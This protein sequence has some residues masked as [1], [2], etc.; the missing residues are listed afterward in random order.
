[1]AKNTLAIIFL[2]LFFGGFLWFVGG[3]H[4]DSMK[5]TIATTSTIQNEPTS[6]VVASHT[7][8]YLLPNA[9][10]TVMNRLMCW[11]CVTDAHKLQQKFT[12]FN[13]QEVCGGRG[14]VTLLFTRKQS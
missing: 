11:S 1:M 8:H 9:L 12:I 2:I 6:V 3:A 14:K 4:S 7:C 13:P 10:D 5:E